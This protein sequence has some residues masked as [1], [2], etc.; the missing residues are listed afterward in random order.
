MGLTP[1]E[2]LGLSIFEYLAVLDGF[3]DANDPNGHK[4]L[5]ETERDDL[6]EWLEATS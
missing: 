2:V 6:W 5:S 1:Q 4:K 3:I